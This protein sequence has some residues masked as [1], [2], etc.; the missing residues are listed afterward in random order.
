M[1]ARSGPGVIDENFCDTAS[2]SRWHRTSR[3]PRRPGSELAALRTNG[4]PPLRRGRW[5]ADLSPVAPRRK[6]QAGRQ[7]PRKRGAGRG[8]SDRRWAVRR[9]AQNTGRQLV[10][11]GSPR[12]L[13]RY[14]APVWTD[15]IW[16]GSEPAPSTSLSTTDANAVS[17]GWSTL[18]RIRSFEIGTRAGVIRG[19]RTCACRKTPTTFAMKRGQ[20]A[21]GLEIRQA[22]PRPS[23]AGR[24]VRDGSDRTSAAGQCI[25]VP[26][27]PAE[28]PLIVRR[29][30]HGTP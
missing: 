28:I 14:V 2:I 4:G 25:A 16:L 9:A 30:G 17:S 13:A 15:S 18:A 24:R 5:R 6:W 7:V 26:L 23:P 29:K 19:S 10:P 22:R 1:E 12:A 11:H 27:P 3:D 20:H 21:R 8:H